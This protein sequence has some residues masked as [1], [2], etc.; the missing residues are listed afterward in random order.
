RLQWPH[1]GRPTIPA[2]QGASSHPISTRSTGSILPNDLRYM[3][4][5]RRANS[6]KQLLD[7]GVPYK[8]KARLNTTSVLAD[9]MAGPK[10]AGTAAVELMTDENYPAWRKLFQ[11]TR[12]RLPPEMRKELEPR[13][14]WQ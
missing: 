2:L 7:T 9:V 14:A 1:P 4:V 12:R 8:G 3:D 6:L 11:Q 5:I 13:S 10:K